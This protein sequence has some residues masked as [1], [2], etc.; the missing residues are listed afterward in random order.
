LSR[1]ILFA[2]RTC[3]HCPLAEKMLKELG[4]EYDKV[5]ADDEDGFS[6]AQEYGVLALPTVIIRKRDGTFASIVGL[7]GNFKSKVLEALS[8][9]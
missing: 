7:S 8:V 2:S 6:L 1:I 5:L 9:P 4:L 3:P